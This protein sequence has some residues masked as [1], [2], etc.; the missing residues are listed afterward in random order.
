LVLVSNPIIV[1]QG[2]SRRERMNIKSILGIGALSLSLMAGGAM[3]AT[4]AEK[5]AEALKAT[6]AAMD[7]FAAK[8][9]ELKA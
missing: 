7:R 3:A 5:Q 8:K 1:P 4:K 6:A 2:T 9:P